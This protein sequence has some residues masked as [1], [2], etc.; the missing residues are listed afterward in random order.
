M[1]AYLPEPASP[2]PVLIRAIGLQIILEK[3]RP[4][5]SPGRG[6][7]TGSDHC[8][9]F[10]LG[11]PTP[12]GLYFTGLRRWGE[13]FTRDLGT[14]FEAYVGRQLAL[15]PE[16][17][18]HPEIQYGKGNDKSIDWFLV[19]PDL[20]L[21]VEAKL[22]RPTQPLRS[23]AAGAAQAL[24]AA[25]DKAHR[26]LDRT[27]DLVRAQHPEFGHISADRPI[28]GIVVTLEDYHLANSPL[29][30]PWYTKS[31][32]LPTLAVSADEL[33]TIVCL[34]DK[35]ADFLTR[36]I[37]SGTREENLHWALSNQQIGDNPLI[38]AALE[39]LPIFRVEESELE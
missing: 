5:T 1:R 31:T 9:D 25:F 35:T 19:F 24:K 27:F 10:V 4:F 26:Q 11:K 39:T 30:Q 33:E 14:L 12:S 38:R 28:L 15:V 23:G 29:H 8:S 20:L 7:S 36:H 2:T 34:G 21:L 22:A 3:V 18:L 6:P 17:V 16:T 13:A 37:T 32:K